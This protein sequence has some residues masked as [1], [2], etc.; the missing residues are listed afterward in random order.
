MMNNNHKEIEGENILLTPED[1]RKIKKI[2]SEKE[3]K[4]FKIHKHYF[5][6]KF[7]GTVGKEPRH[8]IPL[9]ELKKIFERK[10]QIKRGFKRKGKQNYLYTLC[11]EES[12]NVFVKV[13]YIFDETPPKIFQA[14]RIY[15]NLEKAVKRRY[16]LSFN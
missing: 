5:R 6:D 13:G 3:F 11:Y 9:D 15:R 10:H 12:R 7:T 16:G 14:I 4:D 8:G 2:L 1:L